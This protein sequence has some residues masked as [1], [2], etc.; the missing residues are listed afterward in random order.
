MRDPVPQVLMGAVRTAAVVLTAPF[1]VALL[2][3]VFA[4]DDLYALARWVARPV[5]DDKYDLSFW[6]CL[7]YVLGIPLVV[8]A[9]MVALALV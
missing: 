1:A 6:R 5:A 3:L 7:A 9:G 2:L 8:I 4:L